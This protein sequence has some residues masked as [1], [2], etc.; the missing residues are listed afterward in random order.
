M[1]KKKVN[2]L[3]RYGWYL[4]AICLC[5]CVTAG[6]GISFARYRNDF[7]TASFW[8]SSAVTETILMHGEVT[9][10]DEEAV[11]SGT[12]PETPAMW[13]YSGS[14]A[15]L[16]FSVSNGQSAENFAERDQNFSVELVASLSIEDPEKLEV[17]LSVPDETG[18]WIEYKGTAEE[19][20]EGTRYHTVYGDGWV[21]RFTDEEG[22][23]PVFMLEG[24]ALRYTNC[25]LTVVGD[26][27]SSMLSLEI[28]GRYADSE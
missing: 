3:H 14:E 15:A 21:Y 9:E 4:A 19:L 12:W 28:S 8:F 11:V 22:N 16:R 5:V 7:L 26:I 17:T 18:E 27:G 20:V 1:D 24:G 13:S 10:E 2:I 6:V 23:E 25:V